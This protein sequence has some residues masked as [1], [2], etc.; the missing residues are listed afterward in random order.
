MGLP[1]SLGSEYRQTLGLRFQSP[2]EQFWTMYLGFPM[3][4]AE[5]ISEIFRDLGLLRYCIPNMI[6]C[7]AESTICLIAEASEFVEPA[8]FSQRMGFPVWIAAWRISRCRR[9]GTAITIA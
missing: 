9:L 8:G 4:P 7:L 6:N 1:P 5:T 2:R 3:S